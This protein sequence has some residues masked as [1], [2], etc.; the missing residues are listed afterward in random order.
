MR[1]MCGRFFLSRSGAEM[2]RAFDLAEEPVLAP[3][4]NIAPTQPVPVIRQRDERRVLESMQWGF[5]SRFPTEA[6]GAAA[7]PINARAETIATT[8]LFR[9]AFAERRGIIPADGFYEW[10]QRGKS[11][12]PFAVQRRDGALLAMAAVFERSEGEHGT[13]TSCAIV[14]TEANALLAPLHERMPVL[15]AAEDWSRWL[16]PTLRDRAALGALLR[17]CPTDWLSFHP[18]DRRVNDARC[19]DPSLPEPER[20]LFS[21]GSGA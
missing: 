4:Y 14:T 5:V 12:R 18:V 8:P 17:P 11:T 7:R 21:L 15:L 9:D 19:D 1:A 10:Q 3:R 2:L 6:K 16:D 20:D 13:L